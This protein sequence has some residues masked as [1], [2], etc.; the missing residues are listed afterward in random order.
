[1]R[2]PYNAETILKNKGRC[3]QALRLPS[4]EFGRD[5]NK[6]SHVGSA[7]SAHL[8]ALLESEEAYERLSGMRIARGLREFLGAATSDYMSRL[9]AATEPDPWNFGFAV[10][11][12]I[13]SR[14][15]G[16]ASFTAPPDSDGVVEIAYGIAPD[17]QRKGFATEAAA[18]LVE[19][20]SRDARV[21][22]ICAHTLPEINPSTR[23]L[24]KCGFRNVGQII[25]PENTQVWRWERNSD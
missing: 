3:R 18:A 21:T 13:D 8:V 2:S 7:R 9:R 12:K 19:F 10:I 24:E 1:M 25:D 16:F 6:E 17:Y 4:L 22:T 15:I 23:V 20:A 5:R 14:M 11:H